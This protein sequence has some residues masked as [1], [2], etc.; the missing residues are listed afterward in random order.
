MRAEPV[1]C[2]MCLAWLT[3]FNAKRCKPC[4]A[5][6][7]REYYRAMSKRSYAKSKQAATDAARRER[8]QKMLDS[9]RNT[10]DKS[11]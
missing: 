6:Y 9:M 7:R 8:I 1:R 11:V 2:L 3:H 5:A 4:N 10:L